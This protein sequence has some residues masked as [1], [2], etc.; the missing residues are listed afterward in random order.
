MAGG[1]SS[2]AVGASIVEAYFVGIIITMGIVDTSHAFLYFC[3][4][5]E[6]PRTMVIGQT[7]DTGFLCSITEE[8]RSTIA[9][10]RAGVLSLA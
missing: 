5:I 4:A 9:V 7:A 2:A 10:V 6:I 1:G 8:R 3:I